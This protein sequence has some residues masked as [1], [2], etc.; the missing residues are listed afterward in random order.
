MSL[1]FPGVSDEKL[2]AAVVER[3]GKL[4]TLD[5]LREN[6][7]H[8]AGH[9]VDQVTLGIDEGLTKAKLNK[10]RTICDRYDTTHAIIRTSHHTDWKQMVDAMPTVNNVRVSP[11][12]RYIKQHIDQIR[13]KCR[14][15]ALIDFA[16]KEGSD[17]DPDQVTIGIAPYISFKNAIPITMTEHPNHKGVKLMD[18]VWEPKG[19]SHPGQFFWEP[20]DFADGE[21]VANFSSLGQY[22]LRK[23]LKLIDDLRE[24]DLFEDDQALQYEGL[25]LPSG[26]PLLT[27][28]RQF[29]KVQPVEER[30]LEPKSKKKFRS[31]IPIL[32][33]HRNFGVYEGILPISYGGNRKIA[34]F[35]EENRPGIEYAY[36]PSGITEPPELDEVPE[37][38]KVYVPSY[39]AP[40]LGHNQT[41]YVKYA[42]EKNGAAILEE[43]ESLLELARWG[44]DVRIVVNGRN[45]LI[46]KA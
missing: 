35:H 40:A 38:M 42:L 24:T 15:Q 8:L 29:A 20:F 39:E 32:D 27:Q 30:E 2:A 6:F 13:E 28:I 3:G 41:R 7:A 10:I 1:E 33:R 31:D 14:N 45:Y 34:L 21:L 23:S 19:D 17:Y 4:G 46:E 44:E 16:Q 12:D 26:K 5:F 9:V 22:P 36:S 11:M 25:I 43:T 18:V 37:F